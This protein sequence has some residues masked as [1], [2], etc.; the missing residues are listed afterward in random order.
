MVLCERSPH[1]QAPRIR[2]ASPV[3]LFEEFDIST[4]DDLTW[5]CSSAAPGGAVASSE[6]AC[7]PLGRAGE[8]WTQEVDYSALY[9]A[10]E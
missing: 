4:S 5:L 3:D 9:V 7:G 8:P 10:E 2:P 6:G 1:S